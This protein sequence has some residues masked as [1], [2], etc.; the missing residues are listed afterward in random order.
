MNFRVWDKVKQEFFKPTYKAHEG[1]LEYLQI[2]MDG[3]LNR[4]ILNECNEL[5]VEDESIFVGRYE[6]MQ[7]TGRI[8]ED[9][10]EM[11][12]ED[13][14]SD[15]QS[16]AV[17]KNGPGGFTVSGLPLVEVSNYGMKVVGNV[18][19]NPELMEVNP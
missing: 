2:G 18:Y 12:A 6:V 19:E 1:K 10:I 15:D 3:R 14:I 5:E 8:D 7:C 13:I 16:L 17:I 9:G 4:I 11:Y